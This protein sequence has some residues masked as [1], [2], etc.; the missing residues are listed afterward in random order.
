MV[1]TFLLAEVREED[2]GSQS[3][4]GRA[5]R[6]IPI[7]Q[8]SQHLRSLLWPHSNRSKLCKSRENRRLVLSAKIQLSTTQTSL[9]PHYPTA[10]PVKA[11]L[12]GPAPFPIHCLTLEECICFPSLPLK[13]SLCCKHHSLAPG[14]VW[15]GSCSPAGIVLAFP[16]R[17]VPCR[18][19]IYYW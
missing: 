3:M 15:H 16:V 6:L 9:L 7:I 12:E 19:W 10:A 17:D 2:L 18:G 4:K 13:W 5:G 8:A 14:C 1:K 11:L